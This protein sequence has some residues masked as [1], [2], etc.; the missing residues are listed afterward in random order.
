MS[1]AIC[2]ARLLAL[3]AERGGQQR[4]ELR[5][6]FDAQVERQQQVALGR[7]HFARARSGPWRG[8]RWLCAWMRSWSICTST[9][10]ADLP[11]A[12]VS[13]AEQRAATPARRIPARARSRRGCSPSATA[14]FSLFRQPLMTSTITISSTTA[15]PAATRRRTISVCW[16]SPRAG[17]RR[18]GRRGRGRGWGAP[19]RRPAVVAVLGMTAEALSPRHRRRTTKATAPLQGLPEVPK[20]DCRPP[21]LTNLQLLGQCAFSCRARAGSGPADGER[22]SRWSRRDTLVQA[23]P[24]ERHAAQGCA[25]HAARRAR[26]APERRAARRR[27]ARARPLPPARAA[28]R[29]RLRRGLARARRAAAPRGGRQADPARRRTATATRASREAL[30]TA[31][32]SHPAIVALYEACAVRGRVLP[33]LRARRRR[34]ARAADRRR[35]ARRRGGARDR[36]RARRRALPRARPRRDPPRHQAP[37]RARPARLDDR[38][39]RRIR[40]APS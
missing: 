37:E 19:T 18:C 4:R 17:P 33:D 23:P 26:V 36:H 13:A 10:S 40:G 35:R 28:R 20:Y 6:P 39:R 24:G 22:G 29:G 5:H 34:D 9:S 27:R 25:S 2:G 31:R 15:M 14:C 16:S 1:P 32:L 8:R 12:L 3:P 38:A 30:A 7:G 21:P 11:A